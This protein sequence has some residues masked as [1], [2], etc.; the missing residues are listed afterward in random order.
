MKPIGKK[1]ADLWVKNLK[2]LM[3]DKKAELI[4]HEQFFE[5]G[6][7]ERYEYKMTIPR[8]GNLTISF[9]NDAE[10]HS[11]SVFTMFDRPNYARSFGGNQYSGK[12][13]FHNFDLTTCYFEFEDFLNTV[14]R[15]SKDE[16]IPT[17]PT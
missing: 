13:N 12:C 17:D 2:Q 5:H 1:N 4:K 10:S 14:K 7:T 16:I 3:E 8:I 11:Y 15:L 9:Y 6:K